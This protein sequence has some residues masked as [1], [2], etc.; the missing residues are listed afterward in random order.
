[1]QPTAHLLTRNPADLLTRVREARHGVAE[2]EAALQQPALGVWDKAGPGLEHAAAV[3]ADVERSLSATDLVSLEVRG[4]IKVEIQ[5]LARDIRRINALMRAAGGVLYGLGPIAVCDARRLHACRDRGPPGYARARFRPRLNMSNLLSTLLSSAN[6][7]RAYD[8]AL[9]VIQNNVANASTPGYARQVQTLTAMPFSPEDGLAGGVEAG[10][11]VNRRSQYAEQAVRTRQ[12]ALGFAGQRASDLAA[13]EPLFAPIADAGISGAMSKLFQSFSQLAV[14]PNSTTDRRI[15]LDRAESLAQSVRETASGLQTGVGDADS[16]FISGVQHLNALLERVRDFN[17]GRR[18]NG[19]DTADAG[20]DAQLHSTLEDLSELVE[21]QALESGDGTLSILLGGREPAVIGEH[22]YPVSGERS[23]NAVTMRN[24][25]GTDITASIKGGELGA[26]IDLRNNMLPAYMQELNTFATGFAEKINSTLASGLD[27]NGNAPTRPAGDLFVVADPANPA[28]SIAVNSALGPDDVA[29]AGAGGP[30]GN[31][32]AIALARLAS[33]KTLNGFT[34]AE[35]LGNVGG[36]VGR[37]LNDARESR[38]TQS[39]LLTQ[40]K[41][42]RD[43][44]QAVSLDEE[45]ALLLSFQKNYEASAR[46]ITIIDE[47]TETM[48]NLFR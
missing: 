32:N 30:G 12:S 18:A 22:V 43:Q 13:I 19:G 8:Q 14:T 31:A 7:L 4:E 17:A 27:I 10:D 38:V 26:L 23:N 33:E 44:K 48:L 42:L 37:D 3:L 36:H 16:Q 34:F 6:A 9:N 11:L 21:F 46:V 28:A 20:V 45:A 1:M 29:A 39:S 35:A 25:Q 47:L 24:S 5:A 40:A 15:V 2:I 41:S